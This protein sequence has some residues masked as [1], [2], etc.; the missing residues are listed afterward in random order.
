MRAGDRQRTAR[1]S[2]QGGARVPV[3]GIRK[4]IENGQVNGKDAYRR[5]ADGKGWH[6]P[7]DRGKRRPAEP[8]ESDRHKG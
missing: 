5:A 8:E 6:N 4:V 7:R 2:R 3:I 1:L